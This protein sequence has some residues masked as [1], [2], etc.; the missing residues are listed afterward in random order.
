MCHR[1]ASLLTLLVA[2]LTVLVTWAV[3]RWVEWQLPYGMP[4]S[5]I[6]NVFR[7]LRSENTGIAFRLLRGSPLVLWLSAAAL[8]AVVFY[9]A[10]PLSAHRFGWALLGLITGGGIANLLDRFG[11]GRVTDYLDVGVGTW[12]YATF[13]LPDACLVV[14]MLV[15][16][17]VLLGEEKGKA[18]HSKAH[19]EHTLR[20]GPFYASLEEYTTRQIVHA[21]AAWFA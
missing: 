18:I 9:L 5:V 6:G 11:D 4:V 13:N 10:R 16:M 2:A 20:T 7:L 21:C 12:R 3:R 1:T 19:Q 8:L 15:S 17:W 14:G